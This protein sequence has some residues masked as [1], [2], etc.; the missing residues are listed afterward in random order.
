MLGLSRGVWRGSREPATVVRT[1]RGR[2]CFGGPW[3]ALLIW[4]DKGKVE[5]M[6]GD[7]RRNFLVPIPSLESFD[8]LNAHLERIERD[9]EALLTLPAVPY[10]ACAEQVGRVTS[11]S[12]V[13][14][15]T[16]DYSVPVAYDAG[17]SLCG[18]TW[19]KWSSAAGPRSLPG[20][21][22][23]MSGTTSCTDPIHYLPLLGQ[24]TSALDQAA[25]LQGRDLP[26]EFGTL[27]RLLESRMGP[28][29]KGEFV[30]VLRLLETFR[31]EEVHSAVRDA[32]LLGVM[33]FDA[34]KHLVLCRLEGLAA[35]AGPGVVSL[36]AQG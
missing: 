14:Y 18:A 29:G 22:A 11:L 1:G 30:Y 7:V 33:S 36:P 31:L 23:P 4:F 10:D 26:R 17:T 34:V 24:K 2:T 3:G 32:I 16:N 9:R 35:P 25:P 13:R 28:R 15:R 8:A 12:L 21:C 20:I 6:V 19:M 5:G 27:R